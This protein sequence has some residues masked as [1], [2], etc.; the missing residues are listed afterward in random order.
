MDYKNI[1]LTSNCL[2][3]CKEKPIRFL[4][5]NNCIVKLKK[6]YFDFHNQTNSNY[7]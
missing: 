3:R 5:W 6:L 7:I 1:Y 2:K 4:N